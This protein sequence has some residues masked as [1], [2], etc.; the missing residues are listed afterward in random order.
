M[1][2]LQKQKGLTFIS[3]LVI[4]IVAGFLVY[5]GIKITPVYID[6]YAVKAA[7]S[8]VENDPLTARKSKREIR[9]MIAK[10]LDVNNI[11]HVNRDHINIKRS[12]KNTIISIAYEER[13]PIVYNISL[14][15]TFE[16][17]AELTAN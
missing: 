13:R 2:S 11:R 7:L 10:R 5:V 17:T 8:S 4:L 14:L 1:Q 9:N 16:E 3:W 15:M 12:G 6:H